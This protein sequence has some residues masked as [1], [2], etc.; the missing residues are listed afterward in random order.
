MNIKKNN[1]IVNKQNHTT[2]PNKV[3]NAKNVNIPTKTPNILLYNQTKPLYRNY[4]IELFF[5]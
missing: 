5:Y 2:K 4:I 3:I 1:H